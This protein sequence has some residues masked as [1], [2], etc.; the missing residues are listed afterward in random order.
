MNSIQLHDSLLFYVLGDM[1]YKEAL[2]FIP[3]WVIFEIL[4][5]KLLKKRWLWSNT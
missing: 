2:D 4:E 5:K 1:L 3:N